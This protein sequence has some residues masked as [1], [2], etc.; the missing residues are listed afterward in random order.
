MTMANLPI[1][2]VA[3]SALHAQSTR[4]NTIASN[5]ANADNVGG[6]PEAVYRPIMPVFAAYGVEG[7]GGLQ[8]VRVLRVV[9]S[10]AE[11]IKRYEPGHPQADAEGYI[12]APAMD[13][14]AAMVDMISASRNYQSSVEML[15][16]AKE[17]ALATLSINR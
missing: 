5:L 8:G 1:F 4:L 2:E 13:P 16:T 7:Q 14:V 3:G 15:N 6:D 9:E 10:Q 17:L 11:P 12:H